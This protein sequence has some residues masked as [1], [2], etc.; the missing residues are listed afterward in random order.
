MKCLCCGEVFHDQSLLKE[1]YVTFHNVDENNYF[2]KKLFTRDGAFVPEMFLM[3]TFL[4]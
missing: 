2:F 1:H 4:F 3:S